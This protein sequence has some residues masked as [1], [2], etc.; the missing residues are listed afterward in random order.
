[1]DPVALTSQWVAAARANETDRPDGLFRDPY[2]RALAGPEGFEFFGASMALRGLTSADTDDYLAIR[3]RFLDDALI[4]AVQELGLQQ[5]VI[6]AAGM[7]SR[8]IRLPWPAETHVFELD[9]EA[10]FAHKEAILTELGATAPCQRTVVPVDLEHDWVPTLVAAEFQPDKPAAFLAEGLL[11]YLEPTAA[12]GLLE[13]VSAIAAPGSWLA[14]DMAD[15]D[16]L[17]SPWMTSALQLLTERGCPWR[18]A[19]ASP[20]D[21]LARYGWEAAVVMAGEPA[22]NYGRWQYPVMPRTVRGFPRSYLVTARK[23]T[24]ID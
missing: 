12:E 1:M 23:A 24:T 18:F 7:D 17:S 3:T 2:A 9:R 14:V 20:E 15:P 13:R 22:A 21:L 5:V 6:L 4:S 11:V 8:A 10:V 16:L 19:C